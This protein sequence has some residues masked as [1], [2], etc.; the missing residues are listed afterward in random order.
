MRNSPLQ[1]FAGNSK[2]Y[3]V[4]LGKFG[5]VARLLLWTLLSALLCVSVA[6]AGPP[7]FQAHVTI[8]RDQYGVPHIIGDSEPA[9]FFGYGYAQAQDHLEQ[10][11]LQYRDAQGRRS[12]VLGREALG[13]RTLRFTPYEYRW[14]GDYMQR[15]LRTRQ[16]VADN[17]QNIDP[18]VSRILDA[19]A[20]G[21]NYYIA[22][23]RAE[24]PSW[25]DEISALDV[26]ALERSNYMRF[27]SIGD[28]LS[29]IPGEARSY[30]KLGSNQWAIEPQKSADGRIF[31][32][33]HVHMPWGGRFQNYE[34]HLIT[35]GRLNVAGISWFGSP[36]FLVGFN[37]KITWSAT[38]NQP[39]IS[40]VYEE[41]TNPADP[42]QYLYEG[43]WRKMRQESTTF[44]VKGPTGLMKT[45]TLPLYYT[46][47][48]PVVRF[49]REQNR[50][51]SVKLPNY[52]GVNY[53][54]GL[55]FLM[56]ADGIDG[57]KVA[58]ARQLIPRWNFL[59][60]TSKDVYW[61]HNAVV[62]QRNPEFDWSRPVP[63]WLKATEWGP[64][65]P[66][67]ANPQLLNPSSGFVQNCNNPPW[68]ATR[69][70]RLDPGDPTPYYLEH[71][72]LGVY[73]KLRSILG[74]PSRE[75]ALNARGERVFSL[76]TQSKKFTLD[77]MTNMAF[78]TYI[79][80][81][82]VIVPL[83]DHASAAFQPVRD[84]QLCRA[85]N[86]L[87]SWDRRSSP[88]SSAFTYLFYWAKSYGDLYSKAS[89]ERFTGSHRGSI[90]ID[91]AGEQEK[92]W[93]ALEEAV[94]RLQAKFGTAEVPWGKI[95]VVVRGGRF[96][97]DGTGLFDVL[98]PDDGPEEPDGQI[99]SNDGWGHLMIVKESEPKQVWSL[100]PY[101]ESEHPDSP[102][103]NDQ[104]I[105]HSQRKLK[106][107]WFTR[108]EILRNTESVWGDPNRLLRDQPE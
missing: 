22:E 60:T 8:Y 6:N 67:S 79:L 38:W 48:G 31:H 34:A 30:P 46:Q 20:Q 44:Q 55:Y 56:K 45:V 95:N 108:D 58:L 17:K 24:V 29:K 54:L 13:E 61:V 5:P 11:M 37:Q 76:L 107:F 94:N 51:Y 83:L 65:L 98:H 26:E 68:L 75:D 27:Y 35:P 93:R 88:D 71:A 52:D 105:L 87:K 103:Y 89:L 69:N 1:L 90:D 74:W 36:F 7:D 25:I 99:H 106:R 32:V 96:P 102:H 64:Y 39:N 80:A 72:R 47:H 53:S 59:C 92:A 16:C 100:L 77:D 62:A 23:H 41:R 2:G 10:L 101:G 4:A 42:K 91:A 33:E 57:F 70:S 14:G 63:G 82:N 15:L 66:F 97:L 84:S 81:A 12:E 85:I 18:S 3:A 43:Q 49:E 50:A 19:F 28:A 86:T 21:V 104:A 78:D 73:D 40:D 9:T